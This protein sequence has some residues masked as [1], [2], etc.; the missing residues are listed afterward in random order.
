MIK[1]YQD[2]RITNNME[3]PD[4]YGKRK[5]VFIAEENGKRGF[6][7]SEKQAINNLKKLKRLKRSKVI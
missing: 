5:E 6:G 1:V 2:K 7:Y 3:L 4:F